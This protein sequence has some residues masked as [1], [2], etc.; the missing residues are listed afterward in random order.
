MAAAT[1]TGRKHGEGLQGGRGLPPARRVVIGGGGLAG[2]TLALSLAKGSAGGLDV[3]VF[4]PA[5]AQPAPGGDA[6][7]ASAIAA[8][9]RRMFEA[10]GVWSAV[11][12]RAE[13]ILD[14]VITDSRLA[15]PVRPSILNFSGEVTPGEPFAHMVENDDLINALA[16]ACRQ[17]G[18][19]LVA[20]AVTGFAAGPDRV[21]VT[22]ASGEEIEAGLLVAA[23][24]ARS[25]LRDMADIGWI[26]RSYGQV[27]IV[28]TIG[29]ERPH[30]GRAI[31]HF[32]PSGPFAILPLATREGQHRSSIVWT[33]RT[34]DAD[35]LL[36]LPAEDL[37][38]EL[39][40]RFGL[41]L[42]EITL[43]SPA[44][45]FPLSIGIARR[46]VAQRFALVGDA[47]HLVHPIAG[48]GINIGQRDVAVLAEKII[49][50]CRL[51][52]DVA[53][54]EALLAYERARRFDT[55]TMGIATDGLNRLFS[56]DFLPVRL[57]RDLGFGLVERMP[58]VKRFFIREAAGLAGAVPRLMRGEAL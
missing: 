26:G 38:E 3:T 6:S 50:A 13:P 44:R 14:M 23:D 24:G 52:R 9:V 55:V 1:G 47:A 11:A 15:D 34:A 56:N 29:H 20:E 8:G 42:G 27:G 16:A 17:A 57:V 10:L 45:G 30:G 58:A 19:T 51:G 2:L 25:R 37:H 36:Q 5:L 54:E 32:L 18:V 40:R 33:E 35:Y 21:S 7:R 12:D 46:F 31:E 39:E 22:T 53:D 48:Q 28:A 43:L 49:D 41:E 4:D